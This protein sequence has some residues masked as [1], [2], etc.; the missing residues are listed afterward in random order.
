ME[1]IYDAN[2]AWLGTAEV[3]HRL[4]G[5]TANE[6]MRVRAALVETP[7]TGKEKVLIE[8]EGRWIPE[9]QTCFSREYEDESG[10][11]IVKVNPALG[12]KLDAALI[13]G[14]S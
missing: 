14:R 13:R 12:E 2:V 8:W 7:K 9:H 1:K 3:N 5:Q 10:Y 11:L 6:S 4:K